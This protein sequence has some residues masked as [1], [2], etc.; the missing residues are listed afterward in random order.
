MEEYI[1]EH[2]EEAW[3]DNRNF[4]LPLD[5]E[6]L[7]GVLSSDRLNVQSEYLVWQVVHDW[8]NADKNTIL[9]HYLP[10]LVTNCLRFGLFPIQ[11][12]DAYIF[13][14]ALFT[15]LPVDVQQ[16]LKN[17]IRS[18]HQNVKL[19]STSVY[20]RLQTTTTT[21]TTKAHQNDEPSDQVLLCFDGHTG[22]TEFYQ[23][24]KQRWSLSPVLELPC[25]LQPGSNLQLLAAGSK[26]YLAASNSKQ[27]TAESNKLWSQNLAPANAQQWIERTAMTS[28]RLYCSTVV[29]EDQFLFALGGFENNTCRTFASCERYDA[30][31]NLWS[32]VAPLA[33]ARYGAAATTFLGCIYIAG[34]VN[35]RRRAELSVER[36]DPA[37]SE[38]GEEKEDR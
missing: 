34:G 17:F 23:F 11:F 12:I 20:F 33:V 24:S 35:V 22:L 5:F 10:R 18:I 28:R 1:V 37:A 2:F 16:K 21:T 3:T 13:R 32:P 6:T 25:R 4:I 31:R 30:A 15:A 26:L 36:Y 38:E 7:S 9:M 19:Y 8:V 29:F 27:V 14:C